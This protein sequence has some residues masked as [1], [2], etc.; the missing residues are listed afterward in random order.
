MSQPNN[1]FQTMNTI[2]KEAYAERVKDLIPDGVKLLNMIKFTA[3]DKQPG[4]LYHQP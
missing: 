4:N 2:F 3:A 1:D